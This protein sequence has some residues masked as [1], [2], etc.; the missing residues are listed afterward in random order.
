MHR[1]GPRRLAVL[2][3]LADAQLDEVGPV[4]RPVTRGD[5]V[6]GERPCPF[7]SCRHHLYLDVAPL[8]GSI[9]F[10]FPDID[11][12]QLAETCSL[13]VADRGAV[14]SD[15]VGVLLNL[16]RV[17]VGQ[18]ELMAFSRMKGELRDLAPEGA[19]PDAPHQQRAPRAYETSLSVVE[20]AAPSADEPDERE[21]EV[22]FI[23][24]AWRADLL[25]DERATDAALWRAWRTYLGQRSLGASR[26]R[27]AP[28]ALEKEGTD[29]STIQDQILQAVA[30][31]P[32]SA[33]A[34]AASTGLAR[35][36]L[37][38][39]LQAL[40]R[41]GKLILIGQSRQARWGTPDT[42]AAP[43]T[44]KRSGRAFVSESGDADPLNLLHAYRAQLAKK[45]AAVDAA[46]EALE[47]A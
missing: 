11:V 33:N 19:N 44:P 1:L 10:N 42:T 25:D 12:D 13:D 15:S 14:S 22:R 37:T 38:Y 3:Q 47:S 24:H 40:R 36:N 17:R 23:G 28:E 31:E 8:T 6:D 9:K 16:T 27:E 18:L 26:H 46:I 21:T 32:L 30:S 20:P 34:I 5:C 29:M 41:A 2:G 4:T 43:P 35:E 39:H 7:V 45:L